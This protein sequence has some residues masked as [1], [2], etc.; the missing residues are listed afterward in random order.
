VGKNMF[1]VQPLVLLCIGLDPFYYVI[2]ILIQDASH[3]DNAD[4]EEEES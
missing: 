4:Q 1:R 3:H 2:G